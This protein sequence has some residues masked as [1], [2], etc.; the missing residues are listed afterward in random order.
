MDD[1]KKQFEAVTIP[2][3]KDTETSVIDGKQKK[4]V[5]WYTITID[6]VSMVAILVEDPLFPYSFKL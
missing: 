4:A 5:G 1:F 3:P 6:T 2:Y